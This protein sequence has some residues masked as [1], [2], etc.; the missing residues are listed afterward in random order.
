MT[1]RQVAGLI[2]IAL[3]AV[4]ESG[5]RPFDGLPVPPFRQKIELVDAWFVVIEESS[6]RPAFLAILDAD[7]EMREE[8]QRLGA[9]YLRMD[10]DDAEQ[11]RDRAMA[12][13]LPAYLLING[14]GRLI[15]EG[16]L[17]ETRDAVLRIVRQE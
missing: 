8:M 1:W 14:D 13:G 12:F 10:K 15:S 5:W 7:T 4:N 11:Y 6:E 2:L 16:T 17:P 3:A 9:R